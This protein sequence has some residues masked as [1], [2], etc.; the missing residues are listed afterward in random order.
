MSNNIDFVFPWVN[1][2]DEVWKNNLK[3][4]S[5]D[6]KSSDD[7]RFI[8]TPLLKYVFRSID[9]YAPW[10]N[11][12]HL[13][14][15]GKSQLLPWM[16]TDTI[17]VVEHEEFIHPSLIPVFNSNTI[18]MFLS[19]IPNL[20]EKFIYSN[21]DCFFIQRAEESDFFTK[22][23]KLKFEWYTK[24]KPPAGW[25]LTVKRSYDIV[26]PINRNLV[27]VYQYLKPS[28]F[29]RPMKKS[30]AKEFFL[31]NKNK[32]INSCTRF[33]DN[34][35]NYNQ[36][37]YWNYAILKNLAEK[38]PEIGKYIG[39]DLRADEHLKNL[40]AS[41]GNIKLLCLNEN[42]HTKLEYK[43]K[44]VDILENYFPD[45]SKYEI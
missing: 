25:L 5:G 16:N 30:I 26:R 14:V 37:V 32:L 43:E 10:I 19:K 2:N 22:S 21:D 44:L 20:S 13:L 15:S 27:S 3:I 18:E 7:T 28:H 40:L 31:L 33:R 17:N 1:P 36:Y 45:K 6:T 35:K 34:S 4:F 11:K 42:E 12:L 8:E 9:K 41:P 23:G 38:S 29:Q 24:I 39:I